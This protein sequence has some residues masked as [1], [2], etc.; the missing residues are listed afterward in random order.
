MHTRTTGV[1]RKNPRIHLEIRAYENGE[2]CPYRD[3]W[4][5]VRHP[6]PIR[7]NHVASRIMSNTGCKQQRNIWD[8]RFRFGLAP[9]QGYLWI[10]PVGFSGRACLVCFLAAYWTVKALM[11]NVLA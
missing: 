8:I 4:N 2:C 11:F 3:L 1:D 10:A 6:N 9:I 5:L 7:V